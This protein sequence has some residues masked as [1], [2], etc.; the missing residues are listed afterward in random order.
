MRRISRVIPPVALAAVLLTAC[1]E[2]GSSGTGGGGGGG[3]ASGDAC[4]PVAGDQLVVLE[5]DQQLQNADNVVPAVNAATAAANPALLP[6]LDAVSAAL[7]TEDLIDMN[8]AVD[9]ERRSAEEVAAEWVEANVD[10]SGLEQGSGPIVVGGA[11][12]TE[13]TIL[14]NVYADVLQAAGFDASVTEVGNRELY[15]PALQSGADIQVFPEYLATVTDFLN[16]Q[17][18]G[19]DAEGVASGDVQET[20]TALQPLAEQAG[21]V[22]G[23]PSEAADQNAFAVTETFADQ[24]GVSTLSELAD[25]CGDGSLVLGGPAECPERPQ[26]QPG[27]EETYGLQFADF[28]E[29]DAGGP[30][31]KSA[32]Q[33]GEVSIGLVFSSDG[34]LAQ[35]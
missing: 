14:A 22:F 25:A 29:L 21:L 3:T 5:D 7:T 20:V 13:S 23:E 26:C 34:A 10:T 35:G 12:F 2:S 30:L 15:L 6:A 32:I 11:N 28:R 24:V 9:L 18:N 1:G 17:V 4:A 31:T 8:A 16:R 33:Q 19:A 27:L